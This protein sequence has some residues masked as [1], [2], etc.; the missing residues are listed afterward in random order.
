MGAVVDAVVGAVVGNCGTALRTALFEEGEEHGELMLAEPL[1]GNRV[2]GPPAD[3]TR[4]VRAFTLTAEEHEAVTGTMAGGWCTTG[5]NTGTEGVNTGT[6]A[7]GW[8]T[9]GGAGRGSGAGALS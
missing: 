6:M 9:T 4:I 2:H 1:H 5:V 7:G 8:C 3:L